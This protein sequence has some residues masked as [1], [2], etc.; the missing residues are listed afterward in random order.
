MVVEGAP[1]GVVVVERDRVVD[2]SLPDRLPDAVDLV[3][4]AVD[5]RE[6][7]YPV[8]LDDDY[9]VWSAFDN[10]YWPALYFVDKDGVIR[11][12]HFGE[13]RYEQSE[14]LIQRLLDVDREPVSVEGRGVEAEADWSNLRTPETYLGYRRGERFASPDEAALDEPH[15]YK[16]VSYTHLTLP[17]IYSV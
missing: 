16:P 17:T 14:R 7:D 13:G 2:P 5:D 1:D 11:D 6:I 8:A 12:H 15:V 10:H 3:R 4:R 9:G